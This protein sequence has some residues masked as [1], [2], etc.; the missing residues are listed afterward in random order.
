MPGDL[1]PG[2]SCPG[3]TYVLPYFGGLMPGDLMSGDLCP[4]SLLSWRTY[5]RSPLNQCRDLSTVMICSV[6]VTVQA[7]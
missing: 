1:C 7:R 5:V 4:G 2:H 6:L 3:G